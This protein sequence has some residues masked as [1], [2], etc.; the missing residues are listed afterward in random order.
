MPVSY[1]ESDTAHFTIVYLYSFSLLAATNSAILSQRFSSWEVLTQWQGKTATVVTWGATGQFKE[2]YL[3][4]KL[5]D[6]L[7]C[8][9][10]GSVMDSFHKQYTCRRKPIK[11][12]WPISG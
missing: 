6:E 11:D 4:F 9:G 10:G 12:Q 5:E 2:T 1:A 3:E 8:Q 7:F